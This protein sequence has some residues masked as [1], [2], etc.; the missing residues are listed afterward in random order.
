MSADSI[1]I[2]MEHFGRSWGFY[3]LFRIEGRIDREP[4]TASQVIE[5][6][7]RGGK[8]KNEGNMV[9]PCFMEMKP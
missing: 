3:R 2:G 7:V 4:A 1:T 6:V 5:W 9:L 8:V